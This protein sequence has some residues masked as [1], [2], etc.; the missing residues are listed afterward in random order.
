MCKTNNRIWNCFYHYCFG[1]RH[2]Q[3][4]KSPELLN[5]WSAKSK[6]IK[7]LCHLTFIIHIQ[8]KLYVKVMLHSDDS[9]LFAVFYK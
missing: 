5:L 4:T 1:I 6:K 2:Q 8:G 9:I 3:N 7:I